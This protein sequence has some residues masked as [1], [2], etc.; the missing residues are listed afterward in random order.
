MVCTRANL[1]N[2]SDT[3]NY[4]WYILIIP[5]YFSEFNCMIC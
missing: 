2:N 3:D 5:D 4:L 1:E